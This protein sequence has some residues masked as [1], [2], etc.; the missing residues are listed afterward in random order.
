MVVTMRPPG[1]VPKCTRHRLPMKLYE[2]GEPTHLM[3]GSP[4]CHFPL[5]SNYKECC[6]D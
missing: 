2:F 6:L 4:R 3:K 5:F 1:I